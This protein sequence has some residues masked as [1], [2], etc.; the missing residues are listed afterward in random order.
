MLH[1]AN[2]DLFIVLLEIYVIIFQKI[3]INFHVSQGRQ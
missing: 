1:K 3:E 2:Q